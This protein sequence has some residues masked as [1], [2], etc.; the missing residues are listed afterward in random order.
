MLSPAELIYYITALEGSLKLFI[1][2]HNNVQES[3]DSKAVSDNK[4]D[5]CDF[6]K[7]YG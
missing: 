7:S 2:L 6:D 5:S 4:P 1:M 3:N